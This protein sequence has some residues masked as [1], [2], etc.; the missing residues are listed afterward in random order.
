[1]K[2]NKLIKDDSIG[3]I[4]IAG[5]IKRKEIEAG[6][7]ILEH[8]GFKIKTGLNLYNIS[9]F[10]YLA[11]NDKKRISDFYQMVIDKE[12]RGIICSRGGYGSMRIINHL[13]YNILLQNPK[14]FIGYSDIT[15]LLFA[16]NKMTNLIT[17]HGPMVKQLASL[18]NEDITWL[19]DLLRGGKNNIYISY[20]NILIPGKTKGI[21]MGGNLSIICSLI[22]TPF[23]PNYKDILLFI[24]DV[25]EPYYKIDR[26]LTHLKLS[27]FL[28]K[29]SGLILGSFKGCGQEDII[30]Q[31]IYDIIKDI[32]FPCIS[33]FPIGHGNRNITIPIGIKA[34]LNTYKKNIKF[35]E[36]PVIL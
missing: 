12:V 18:N 11:G 23:M 5:P 4:S 15:A 30:N 29:V 35:L 6:I 32:G 17:F 28:E 27:G 10:G 31:I 24:E 14:V 26:M 20:A 2:P 34:E 21:L 19:F 8:Y 7:Q 16:I 13:E 36:D 22:G 9:N 1:M 33:N 25:N 3:I